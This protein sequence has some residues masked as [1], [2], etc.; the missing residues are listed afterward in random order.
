M[1]RFL[2]LSA[3]LWIQPLDAN[4]QDHDAA[5]RAK[6]AEM[7]AFFR[8]ASE[9]CEGSVPQSWGSEVVMLQMATTPAMREEEIKA[10]EKEVEQHR[11][12]L[13][14]TRWCELYAVEMREAHI[15]F[16][17]AMKGRFRQQK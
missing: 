5:R 15:I 16:D 1:R 14:Q 4:S 8:L 13:G 2:F 11:L 12:R 17:A 3:A 10:K 6:L 7:I 9:P